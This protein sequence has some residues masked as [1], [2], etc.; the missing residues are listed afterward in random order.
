MSA[1]II[2]LLVIVILMG[3]IN[4]TNTSIII[5]FVASFALAAQM[6]GISTE[7]IISFNTDPFNI[8]PVAGGGETVVRLSAN[9][10]DYFPGRFIP[11]AKK[12]NKKT[13]RIW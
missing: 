3:F 13:K 11:Q 8:A 6:S 1:L 2:G 9:T 4:N 7:D 5:S 12:M 10:P